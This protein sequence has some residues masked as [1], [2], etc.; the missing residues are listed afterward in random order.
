MFNTT[1]FQ[2]SF[3]N[4][5]IFENANVL[6]EAIHITANHSSPGRI[7][8]IHSHPEYELIFCSK[9]NYSYS[10]P[11]L[12]KTITINKNK[13]LLIP[14]YT[15]HRI[16]EENSESTKI[17][18]QFLFTAKSNDKESFYRNAST[19]LKEPQLINSNKFLIQDIHR[20]LR[21]D[22]YEK[23][24]FYNDLLLFSFGNYVLDAFLHATENIQAMNDKEFND[25]RLDSAVKYINKNISA[26][27]TVEDVA[28]HIHISKRQLERLFNSAMKIS[29]GMYLKY[30]R[31][32][33]I[34]ALLANPDLSLENIS[35]IMQY[36]SSSSL[37]K[38]F[39][40]IEGITPAKFRIQIYKL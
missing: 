22:Q 26:T 7:S 25:N 18:T 37:I 24:S 28:N 21:L 3:K 38:A 14:P 1:Y 15:K 4:K 36:N 10:F 8:S 34:K 20:I 11:Q 13:F 33:K 35:D 2:S 30:A 27:L 6:I 31:V 17:S 23:R 16:E 40:T 5:L 29:P 32:K 19:K 9:G 12:N 39:K